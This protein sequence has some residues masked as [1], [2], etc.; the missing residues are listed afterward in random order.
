MNILFISV[1]V[2]EKKGFSR[3]LNL[4]EGLVKLGCHV[5]MFTCNDSFRLRREERNGVEI[6]AFPEFISYRLRKGGLGI[7]DT[8]SRILFLWGKKYDV[9]HVDEGFRPA[10][11]GPGHLYAKLSNIPY[12]CDWYDWVGSGGLLDGRSFL[13]KMTLGAWDNYFEVVDKLHSDGIVTISKCLQDRAISI[14]IPKER[15][16][17]IHGGADVCGSV[18]VSKHDAREELGLPQDSVILGYAGMDLFEYKDLEPFLLAVP[19]LKK[20]ISNILWFSTGDALPDGVSEQYCIGEEYLDLGW[21]PIEQYKK[22]LAAADILL[23]PLRDDLLSRSRWPNKVGDYLAAARPIL[24]TNVGEIASYA[25]RFPNSVHI[26]EWTSSSVEQGVFELLSNTER[27]EL[28]GNNNFNIAKKFYS[29][30][31]KAKELYSFYKNIS[32]MKGG[33]TVHDHA[34]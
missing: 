5:T 2:Y 14:G 25:E 26:V 34:G 22:Y 24:T 11:G 21:V 1:G 23:L 18:A 6:V 3:I 9:V 29:W 7:V 15:T 20:K 19:Q 4:A 16:A 10:G 33:E 12:I 30:D 27:M 31:E 28:M 17:I 13:Y 8:I 32:K